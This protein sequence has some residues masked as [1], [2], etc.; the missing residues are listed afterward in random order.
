[1]PSVN[2][3]RDATRPDVVHLSVENKDGHV[4]VTPSDKD[5]FVLKM[6]MAVRAC[7]FAHGIEL[8]EQRLKVLLGR[9]AEWLSKHEHSGAAWLTIR[10]AQWVFVVV[11]KHVE[12][13]ASSKTHCRR[14]N[15]RS[16]ATPILRA[17]R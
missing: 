1:M 9:L 13:T 10:D 8:F 15:W 4:V 2:P 14:W 11:R 17:F 12:Y 5:R 16:P 3:Q 7:Q 6:Q